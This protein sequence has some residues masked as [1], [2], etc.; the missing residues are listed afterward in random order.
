[1]LGG[2]RGLGHFILSFT[3]LPLSYSTPNDYYVWYLPVWNISKEYAFCFPWL[4]IMSKHEIGNGGET[5]ESNYSLSSTHHFYSPECHPKGSSWCCKL[6]RLALTLGSLRLIFVVLSLLKSL[7]FI[8]FYF[9]PYLWCKNT[10][11]AIIPHRDF[12]SGSCV[13][14]FFFQVINQRKGQKFISHLMIEQLQLPF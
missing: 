14:W 10:S 13:Q 12:D 2:R 6:L 11:S 7:D 8:F 4:W 5:Y 1:M 9:I 3:K